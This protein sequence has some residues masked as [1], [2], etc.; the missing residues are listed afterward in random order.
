MRL[1]TQI[2]LFPPDGGMEAGEIAEFLGSECEQS[3][4]VTLTKN[5][6]SMVSV[7]FAG[8]DTISVRL[9]EEFGRAPA[10][11]LRALRTFLRTRKKSAWREV[12]SFA[13]AIGAEGTRREGTARSRTRGRVY[14]L[15]AIYRDVNRSFFSGRVDCHIEWGRRSTRRK[16]NARYRTIH[17]GSWSRS[18]RMI[19]VHPLLDDTEVPAE[20][21]RYIVFHEMLH[22]VVPEVQINGR[23]YDH[24]PQF[25]ALERA[26]PDLDRM[27]RVSKRLVD[28]L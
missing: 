5:R 3:V 4:R 25:R 2:E 16:R 1:A 18:T 14:D 11:V 24:S 17:F 22:A 10:D 20:F 19:R 28:V 8:I 27:R 23:R 26:F 13:R 7:D 12:S 9:H 6:V 21:V 15:M